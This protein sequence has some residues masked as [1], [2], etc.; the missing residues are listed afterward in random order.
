MRT[1]ADGAK[2][3]WSAAYLGSGSTLLMSRFR[4]EALASLPRLTATDVDGVHAAAELQRL[5]LRRNQGIPE[6]TWRKT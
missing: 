1:S 4:S 2:S 6:W 5:R 3:W